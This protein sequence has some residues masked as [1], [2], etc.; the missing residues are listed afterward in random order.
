MQF[1]QHA[2]LVGSRA[3]RDRGALPLSHRHTSC[4]NSV[5]Q[6]TQ[7]LGAAVETKRQAN[8]NNRIYKTKN[9]YHNTDSGLSRLKKAVS[10]LAGTKPREPKCDFER[11]HR[12]MATNFSSSCIP[13]PQKTFFMNEVQRRCCVPFISAA[14]AVKCGVDAWPS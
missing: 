9:I 4:E 2:C 8:V 7:F 6:S 14:G 1:L 3:A 11:L 10:C 12:Q 13:C 5:P